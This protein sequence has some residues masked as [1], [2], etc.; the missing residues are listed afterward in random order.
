[1]SFLLIN[2][3]ISKGEKN[4]EIDKYY[5]SMYSGG[6]VTL[7]IG[8]KTT[9]SSNEYKSIKSKTYKIKLISIS[10]NI[11]QLEIN[12]KPQKLERGFDYSYDLIRFIGIGYSDTKLVIAIGSGV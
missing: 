2:A 8:D 6:T 1:M 4:M 7:S 9:F 10:G 12:D 3:S 11:A 5:E